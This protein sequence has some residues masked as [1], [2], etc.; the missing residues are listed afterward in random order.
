MY[1]KITTQ[2]MRSIN[3]HLPQEFI[4]K[5]KIGDRIRSKKENAP[6]AVFDSLK[7]VEIFRLSNWDTSNRIFE[8]SIIKSQ[9]KWPCVPIFYIKRHMHGENNIPEVGWPSGTVLADEVTLIKEITDKDKEPE[10][11]YKVVD[12]DMCSINTELGLG[13]TYEKNEWILPK[14][15]EAPLMVFNNYNNAHCFL[16][17]L[18]TT[19]IRYYK[20]CK[21][22]ILKSKRKWIFCENDTVLSAVLKNKKHKKRGQPSYSPSFIFPPGTV[23]ADAVKLIDD[24]L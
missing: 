22:E 18:I 24:E 2:D 10:I 12:M 20:I 1:Y 16:N 21:C 4:I 19:T 15:K 13:V 14:F 5:Y 23:F 11:F 9:K 3:L 8:C 6:L 7:E 17:S